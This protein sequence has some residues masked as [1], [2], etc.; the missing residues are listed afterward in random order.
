MT[1]VMLY[2]DGEENKIVEFYADKW[3][4]SK[5][6]TVKRIITEKKKNDTKN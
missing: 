3:N 6:D 1:Q 4:L 2:L 5:G